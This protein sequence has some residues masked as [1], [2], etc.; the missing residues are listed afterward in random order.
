MVQSFS[1]QNCAQVNVRA[2]LQ[3]CII[4]IFNFNYTTRYFASVLKCVKAG[5]GIPMFTVLNITTVNYLLDT[6]KK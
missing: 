5:T 4:L 6:R 3:N 1:Q 2:K